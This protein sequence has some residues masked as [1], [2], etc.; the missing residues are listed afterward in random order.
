M[1]A[2]LATVLLFLP[3]LTTKGQV[4]I[5]ILL[6][7]KLNTGNIEFGLDGGV[8]YANI[9]GLSGGEANALFKYWLLLRYQDQKPP[10]ALSYRS[11]R[12]IF[13]GV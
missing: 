3:T 2:I 11:D 10:V 9:R 7:D 12:E 13:H 5:S 6:G 4:L 1:K 8:N